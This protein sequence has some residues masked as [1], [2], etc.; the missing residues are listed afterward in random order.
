MTFWFAG[1]TTRLRKLYRMNIFGF[2]TKCPTWDARDTGI[3]EDLDSTIDK[4]AKDEEYHGPS[5][6]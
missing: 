3:R 2:H 4:F 6:R 1:I 5:T